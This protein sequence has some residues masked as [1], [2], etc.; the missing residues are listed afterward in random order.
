M[1]MVVMVMVIHRQHLK[2]LI[3]VSSM[4]D[5]AISPKIHLHGWLRD[6]AIPM[7]ESSA[8]LQRLGVALRSRGHELQAKVPLRRRLIV[9]PIPNAQPPILIHSNRCS[10]SPRRNPKPTRQK[11][12]FF[13]RFRSSRL[14]HCHHLA[15]PIKTI[16]LN[17]SNDETAEK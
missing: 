15:V 11:I 16:Q 14:P 8:G 12:K 7:E 1:G 10:Y 6:T 4:V 9:A 3:A 5:P 2:D 17:R 13:H